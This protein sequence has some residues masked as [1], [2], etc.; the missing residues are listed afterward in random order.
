MKPENRILI[1][2]TT[3]LLS[4][5]INA[6]Q[7]LYDQHLVNSVYITIHPDSLNEIFSNPESDHYFDAKFVYTYGNESDTVEN[8]GFRLR[9]NTS[10]YAQKKSFKISFN[11]FVPG[12]TYQDVKKL[13]LNGQ[14][15]DPSMIREKLFYDLWN[16]Y[17][18]PERRSSFVR[19]FINDRYYGLYTNIEEF[20]KKWLDRVF[21]DNDGNLYK[22]T[23][24]ADLVYLGND[25]LQY[26]QL[27]N[28]TVTG[29]RVYDLQTNE[30]EDDY[31]GLVHLISTL[32]L[33]DDN[34]FKMQIDQILEVKSTL[35]A[36][37]LD[38]ASG[39]WDNYMYN[40][41]NFFLYQ[42]PEDGKFTFISYDTDNTF[43]IDW[44]GRDWATRN[45]TDWIN[46]SEERPL[47]E[48]LLSI[49]EFMNLYTAYLDTIT[50]FYC[51]E[52]NIFPHIDSL[53]NLIA[54]AAIEDTMRTKD[55]GYS[56]DDFFNSVTQTIDSHSPYGIKPFISSR[57]QNTLYQ[58]NI[59][60]YPSLQNA[61]IEIQVFPNPC[62]NSIT[63]KSN[64]EINS[65]ITAV[66]SSDGKEIIVPRTIISRNEIIFD[67]STLSSGIYILNGATSE[68]RFI[69]KVIKYP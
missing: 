64:K 13:N 60:S 28:G 50:R 41:N 1:L 2:L 56:D 40:K 49:P 47:A 57:N 42:N 68:G 66:C 15:N 16:A 43:G 36:F 21:T 39:N 61:E 59:Y 6:Q 63:V 4:Q 55:F 10:R 44:I 19:L 51:N 46:H 27:W 26:K 3:L 22:C 8:I 35:K 29:G 9:G 25:P 24:P 7:S 32:N 30:D 34:E 31:S 65:N 5:L 62:V 17:G 37:A 69:E 53:M 58:L 14:H 52:E 67:L 20:D 38:V 48:R 33:K 18:M 12:R 45:C 23:Y 54:E 11:E